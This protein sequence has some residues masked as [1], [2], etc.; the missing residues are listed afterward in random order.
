VSG[1]NVGY[2]STCECMVQAALV[3]LQESSRLP[4]QG[5]VL[6]PGYAFQNTSL[7]DRLSANDVPFTAEIKDL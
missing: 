2:G 7:V 1:K 4:G 5:G 3:V 6:T